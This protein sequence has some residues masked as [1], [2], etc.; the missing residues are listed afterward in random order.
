MIKFTLWYCLNHLLNIGSKNV[1]LIRNL[2]YFYNFFEA[3]PLDKNR[4]FLDQVI[5]DIHEQKIPTLRLYYENICKVCRCIIEDIGIM[6]TDPGEDVKTLSF[7]INMETVFEKYL[8]YLIREQRHLIGPDAK[9]LDGNK[10]GK[11]YLFK[12]SRKYEA[13]PDIIVMKEGQFKTILDAK[14][15]MKTSEVDRYQIIS[16]ALSY[17]VKKAVLILPLSENSRP[18]IQRIGEVGRDNGIELFEYYIELESEN[19]ETQENQLME[20]VTK[21]CA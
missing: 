21:L 12:D 14:Y 20:E 11:R 1:E 7:I 18:G 16:H 17:G 15:K 4:L 5:S 8:L 9:I 10:E 19:L 2:S 3:I 13:K 6:L